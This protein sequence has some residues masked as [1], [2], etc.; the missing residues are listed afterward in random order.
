LA[1]AV[2]LNPAEPVIAQLPVAQIAPRSP[3]WAPQ[4]LVIVCVLVSAIAGA[5]AGALVSANR[6]GPQGEQGQRG[7]Q[8]EQGERGPRGEQGDEGERGQRGT[9]AY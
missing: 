3:P 6:P 7:P 5:A 8:G 9:N 1:A 2:P 4:K